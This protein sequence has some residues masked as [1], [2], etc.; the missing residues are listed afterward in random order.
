M[1]KVAYVNTGPWPCFIGFTTSE[2]AYRVELKRLG[3]KDAVEFLARE[4][5]A[6]ATHEFVSNRTCT[7]IITIAP[8]AKGVSNEMF[9]ALIAHEALHVIQYMR[10]ELNRNEPFC[11]ETESYLLQ[12]IVQ[13]CLQHAWKTGRTRKI[14]P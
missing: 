14:K 4:R 8:Q 7:Y 5:G 2:K 13:H 3:V 12:M 9:A 11:A 10:A 1:D 6:A